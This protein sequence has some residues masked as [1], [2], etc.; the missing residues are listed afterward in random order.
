MIVGKGLSMD[1]DGTSCSQFY[2]KDS[3]SHF[4][5]RRLK[6]ARSQSLSKLGDWR[7]PLFIFSTFFFSVMLE[8]KPRAL[9]M[10]SKYSVKQLHPQICLLGVNVVCTLTRLT[11]I[12]FYIPT[13]NGHFT[14]FSH[15][16]RI[17][18][19]LI[20]F[21]F[22]KAILSL[23]QPWAEEKPFSHLGTRQS[24]SRSI[25]PISSYRGTRQSYSQSKEPIFS[26]LG[27]CQSYSVN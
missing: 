21:I 17:L 14:D 13:T 10:L 9:P 4:R 19:Q 22:R 26:H 3:H 16:P 20:L 11:A 27:I 5:G 24:Y 8:G 15:Q 12:L 18:L 6:F 7:F 1:I 2:R 25:E 23:S